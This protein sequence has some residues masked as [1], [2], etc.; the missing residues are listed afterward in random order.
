M[1]YF[2]VKAWEALKYMS[3]GFE[4]ITEDHI[5]I[6]NNFTAKKVEMENYS[7][8][9]FHPFEIMASGIKF[10]VLEG[11]KMNQFEVKEQL[12][13]IMEEMK[14]L[15]ASIAFLGEEIDFIENNRE[16]SGKLIQE[17]LLQPRLSMLHEVLIQKAKLIEEATD[18]AQKDNK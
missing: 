17:G 18:Q 8:N 10:Y 16:F 1:R 14:H 7:F 2:E 11:D 15:Q 13:E 4:V 12:D 5:G 3:E 9:D 6:K